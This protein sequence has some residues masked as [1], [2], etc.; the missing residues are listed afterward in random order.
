MADFSPEEFS[1]R[2]RDTLEVVSRLAIL[3]IAGLIAGSQCIATCSLFPCAHTQKPAS[4]HHQ[5]DTKPCG[6]Q[7]FASETAPPAARVWEYQDLQTLMPTLAV[8]AP[9][10]IL[11][12]EPV[13]GH[14]PPPSV[15]STPPTIRRI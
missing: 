6:H 10:N 4:C 14:S 9:E 15:N 2:C 5:P 8:I 7:L 13:Q 12:W 11:R 1:R 3:L